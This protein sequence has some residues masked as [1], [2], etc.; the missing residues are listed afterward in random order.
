[1]NGEQIKTTGM[2]ISAISIG[3]YDKRITILTKEL[4]KIQAFVRG[5]KRPNSRFSA[6]AN[7]FA[8]GSFDLYAGRSAY[9]LAAASIS[10]YFDCL[11]TDLEAIYYGSY[12]LELA[13]Y[14]SRENIEAKQLLNLIY[15]SLTAL[16]DSRFPKELVRFI[17]ELKTLV[18]NGEYPDLF[19]CVLCG[20]EEELVGF[21][22]NR[23]G[24]IC[25]NCLQQTA[26]EVLLT[27]SLYAMQYVISAPIAKLFTFKVTDQV[28]E[29]LQRVMKQLMYRSVDRQL[30]SLAFLE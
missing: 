6:V 5:A 16:T 19:H 10:N 25:K 1:M 12:F 18:I 23:N 3:E 24:C 11:K 4:G 9:N 14:Y 26:A 2:V 8:F 7:P 27:S 21:S 22:A 13:D 17:Y 29:N 15:L 20:K 30:K 28:L